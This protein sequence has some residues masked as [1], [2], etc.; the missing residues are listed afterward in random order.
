MFS[1][2]KISY[3]LIEPFLFD[4]GVLESA[5]SKYATASVI[6]V[7]GYLNFR[8]YFKLISFSGILVSAKNF[9]LLLKLNL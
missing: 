4:Q 6:A 5:H 1:K 9:T 7:K 2:E 8:T 3:G